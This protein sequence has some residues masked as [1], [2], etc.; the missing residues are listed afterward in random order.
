MRLAKTSDAPSQKPPVDRAAS[1]TDEQQSLVASLFVEMQCELG[2][3]PFWFEDRLWWVDIEKGL[4][5]S[6]DETGQNFTRDTLK[7]KLGAAAPGGGGRFVV[8]LERDIALF[9]RCSQAIIPLAS[10]DTTAHGARFNDGKCDPH[11]RFIV[12]TLCD[13]TIESFCSLYSF[14]SGRELVKLKSDI[15][16]SNGLAWD[17]SGTKLFYIDSLK[18]RVSGF[19]Y[20]LETGVLGDEHTVISIPEEQGIPDGMAI[21]SDGNLWIALWGGFAVGC[22]SPESGQCLRK[23]AIPC[24]QPT[25]CCFGGRDYRRL[26]ITTARS[27]LSTSE[28]LAHPLAGSIF[29]CDLESSGFPT[30]VF[31]ENTTNL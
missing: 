7:Q 15:I 25:S 4:L 13:S 30:N 6:V 20:N 28:L 21:D 19:T 24:A 5:L 1:S 26:Y 17:R 3:G 8:A 14:E 29:Y 22:W 16:L 31:K 12:G 9:D 27:G 10:H 18:R 2:E 23:I 11:G